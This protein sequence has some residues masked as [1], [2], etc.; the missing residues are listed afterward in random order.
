MFKF[1][2]TSLLSLLLTQS[3][4][5]K[6]PDIHPIGPKREKP[7]PDTGS[8]RQHVT[9]IGW[10]QFNKSP[11]TVV[12]YVADAANG[13]SDTN[14]G[15]WSAT[16]GNPQWGGGIVPD[17]A[18]N[19]PLLT[20]EAGEAHLRDGYPD[21]LLFMRGVNFYGCLRTSPGPGYWT[22]SGRSATEPMLIS[23]WGNASER[24]RI[25]S[26][27]LSGLQ[28][29][30]QYVN[31]HAAGN[32]LSIC[33]IELFPHLYDGTGGHAIG[34]ACYGGPHNITIEDCYIHG[35]TIGI[36]VEGYNV[37]GQGNHNFWD[38]LVIRGSVVADSYARDGGGGLGLLVGGPRAT[39]PGTATMLV[40]STCF[41]GNGWI[42]GDSTTG[43]TYFNH[44]VYIQNGKVN[45]TFRGNVVTGTDG[46][47]QRPG[48]DC[49]YN[50]FLKN[51]LNLQ[52]GSGTFQMDNPNGISGNVFGNV[53]I[54]GQNYPNNGGRGWGLIMGNCNGVNVAYN[55]FAHNTI[56]TAPVPLTINFD[57]GHGNVAGMQN[58]TFTKNIW[59]DWSGA[60][61]GSFFNFYQA[62]LIINMTLD[63]NDFQDSVDTAIVPG[64]NFAFLMQPIAATRDANGNIVQYV[65]SLSQI[66]S[67]NNRWWRNGSPQSNIHLFNDIDPALLPSASFP[68]SRDRTFAQY[69]S[70]IGDTTS[71]YTQVT[72][73][74]SSINIASFDTYIGG[75]GTYAHLISQYRA[76][77]K[78]AYNIAI[79]PLWPTETPVAGQTY[80]EGITAVGCLPYWWAGF[81][82]LDLGNTIV[83]CDNN[84]TH[85]ASGVAGETITI[86]GS[87]FLCGGNTQAQNY[88][89]NVSGVQFGTGG[90]APLTIIDNT[91]VSFLVPSHIP[92]LC[93]ISINFGNGQVTKTAAFT[94]L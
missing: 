71:V 66:H 73:P 11:D 10:T 52:F 48:G 35:Y 69:M 44:N 64:N 57:N 94:F 1:I 49:K 13:G 93:S 47:Q 4:T 8:K 60:G 79:M 87:G 28:I 51:A 15:L 6:S 91:H 23:T 42:D 34:Y 65:N 62:N 53:G 16:A 30:N 85:F 86:T 76:Q 32:N 39:D 70:D 63:R 19:G 88:M 59:F 80:Q 68:P 27:T 67:S 2:I 77:R 21:W 75:P 72:Y 17:G 56:G 58:V 82:L 12:I 54:E 61:R 20:P 36:D 43:G 89:S 55:I 45:S 18:N 40:E 38:N 25:N 84:T 29:W 22:K 37:D 3:T 50:L 31:G 26:G 78:G 46:L 7:I 81:G 5:P 74:N 14:N 9:L 24:P 92:G 83:N 41:L 90:Y 33:G